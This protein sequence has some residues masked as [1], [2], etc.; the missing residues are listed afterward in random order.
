MYL[1]GVKRVAFEEEKKVKVK[2]KYLPIFG[3]VLSLASVLTLFF[4]ARLITYN[5][6][7]T[8]SSEIEVLKKMEKDIC[9]ECEELEIKYN[10]LSK[11]IDVVTIAEEE[12]GMVQRD[13]KLYCFTV[14]DPSN[15]FETKTNQKP[16]L[17]DQSLDLTLADLS[18]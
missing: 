2:I 14:K 15:L 18:E 3:Y 11:S 8:L 16:N 7:R 17:F 4:V 10:Y 1:Y 12:L 9:Q 13:S 5:E 6:C